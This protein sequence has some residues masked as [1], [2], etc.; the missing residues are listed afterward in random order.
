MKIYD[1]TKELLACKPYPGDRLTVLTSVKSTGRDGYNLSELSA[2]VHNGTH[3]DA[4][5]HFIPGGADTASLDLSA[6]VGRCIVVNVSEPIDAARAGV[7]TDKG[8]KRI[9]IKGGGLLTPQAA[10]ILCDGGVVF[11]GVETES[12]A[13]AGDM[14]E[15]HTILLRHGAA[16]AENLD[17]LNVDAGCYFLFAAPLKISGAEGAPCRAVLVEFCGNDSGPEN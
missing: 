11:V 13:V 2:S 17:L 5:L 16:I 10:E 3:I 12:P 1:I 6:C 15:V 9:L 7:I 8:E 14:A 4:P